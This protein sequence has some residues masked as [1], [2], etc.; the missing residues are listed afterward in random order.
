MVSAVIPPTMTFPMMIHSCTDF[1]SR[2][3]LKK[4]SGYA[5][6]AL[7]AISVVASG[8]LFA[9]TTPLPAI[10]L[11]VASIGLIF[12]GKHCVDNSQTSSSPST[13]QIAQNKADLRTKIQAAVHAAAVYRTAHVS[14]MTIQEHI[15]GAMTGQGAGD[16]LGL[17]TEFTSRAQAEGMIAGRPLEYALKDDPLFTAGP[18]N[19]FRRMFLTGMFTDDTEQACCLVRAE[20]QKRRGSL[21]SLEKLFADQL[22]HWSR[23]GLD[24]YQGQYTS[25]LDPRCRDIG[26][27]TREVVSS[28]SFPNDPHGTALN[29]WK[30]HS[31][32]AARE[33]P[34][35]NGAVMRTSVVALM[36]HQNLEEVVDKTILFAAVTHADPRSVAAS[37]A[38]TTAIAL[39]LQGFAS[40]DDV[41]Q[42]ASE[43]AKQVLKNQLM[44]KAIH[45]ETGET[46]EQLYQEFSE[47]LE[48][49][50][51]GNFNT[52]CLDQYPTGYAYKCVGAA[53]HAL[54]LAGNYAAENPSDP[55]TPFRRAIEGVIKQGGDADTNAA[56]AAALI[57]ALFGRDKLPPSWRDAMHPSARAVLTE[58]T[59]MITQISRSP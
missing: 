14:T 46:W 42:H 19:F 30:N 7:G 41:T 57:G 12:F 44:Q 8:I 31:V 38:L 9:V 16:G 33:K 17:L 4:Y 5:L 47:G 23:C 52:L 27:L 56:P 11:L 39:F 55:T 28:P 21:Q 37:V 35:S 13:A 6:I 40:I 24:S 3:N 53:F 54:R 49:H 2:D 59:H 26:N 58:T 22:L 48:A 45:L 20:D 10:A 25:L 51:R 18:A 36:H 15:E 50:L 1:F 34:A 29:V 43:I 32:S